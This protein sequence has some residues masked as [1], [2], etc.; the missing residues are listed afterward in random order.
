VYILKKNDLENIAGINLAGQNADGTGFSVST[1]TA[2]M[3][4]SGSYP[5]EIRLGP[6]HRLYRWVEGLDGLGNA[7]GFWDWIDEGK[8]AWRK[9]KE[10]IRARLADMILNNANITLATV[11]VS[12]VKDNANVR[13]NI[14]DTA[15]D[16]VASRSNYQNAPGGTVKL[17]NRMLAAINKLAQTYSFSISELAGGSHSKHSLHYDGVAFDVNVLN[18]QRV[19]ASHPDVAKFKRDCRSEGATEVLG[20]G[21]AGHAT[22]IHCAWSRP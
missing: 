9:L 20:P 4:G 19:N 22:H 6:D 13:Q 11:H 18:G 8:K 3:Q 1:Q 10:K 16:I 17:D 2:A 5:G 7:V 14:Q 12:G 15:N 21:D